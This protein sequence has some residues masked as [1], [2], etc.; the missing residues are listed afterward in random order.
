MAIGL[1]HCVALAV[2]AAVLA[3]PA[4][5]AANDETT[6]AACARIYDAAACSCA[7]AAIASSG[8]VPEPQPIQVTASN[9]AAVAPRAGM[10]RVAV[11]SAHDIAQVLQACMA[12]GR[13]TPAD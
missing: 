3:A 8:G 6:R 10:A 4:P 5:A 11:F 9:A 7:F 13:D 1:S 2:L 12:P